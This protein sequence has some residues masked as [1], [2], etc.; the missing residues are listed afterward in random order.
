M[1][2][3]NYNSLFATLR[4]VLE[5]R[6]VSAEKLAALTDV[7]KKFIQSVQSSEI[8]KLP[9]RPYVVGYLKKIAAALGIDADELIAEYDGTSG[10]KNNSDRLPVNRFTYQPG[11]WPLL[12]GG[13]VFL[14]FSAFLGYRFN[15]ITGYPAFKVNLPAKSSLPTL[16]I[17]GQLRPRD[18]LSIN[19]Q[20]INS[21]VNGGINT[22]LSL[23]PGGNTLIFTVQRF[24]G[25]EA[26]VTEQVFYQ[27]IPSQTTPA[28]TSTPTSTTATSTGQ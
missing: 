7:P 24:L 27:P 15:D 10:R 5:Q 3:N 16:E 22:T 17:N 28:S 9:S 12:F 6:G 23:N 26:A 4:S 21:D 18:T 25:K 19:G 2:Q 11:L 13:M 1:E 20:T 8:D 14:A